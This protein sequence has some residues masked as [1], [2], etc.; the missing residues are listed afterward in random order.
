MV[1]V[2]GQE[3]TRRTMTRRP[4]IGHVVP[5]PSPL[6]VPHNPPSTASEPFSSKR[7]LGGRRRSA[8]R[9]RGEFSSAKSFLSVIFKK[10]E[11][12]II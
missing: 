10:I 5:A 4:P 1:V 8:R 3:V 9:R 7:G 6:S 11:N 2:A 12:K